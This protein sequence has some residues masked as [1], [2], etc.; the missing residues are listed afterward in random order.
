MNGQRTLAIAGAGFLALFFAAGTATAQQFDD[1]GSALPLFGETSNFAYL[2][3][4]Y[5]SAGGEILVGTSSANNLSADGNPSGNQ[6][7]IWTC[8]TG[9]VAMGS[10]PVPSA[11]STYQVLG[12]TGL[13]LSADGGTAFGFC[14]YQF[15][16]VSGTKQAAQI[17][18]VW[19]P[20]DGMQ[21]LGYIAG[22]PSNGVTTLPLAISADGSVVTGESTDNLKLHAFRWTKATGIWGLGTPPADAS[23]GTAISADG[24]VIT[25]TYLYGPSFLTGDLFQ[26]TEATGIAH[27]PLPA[28]DTYPTAAFASADGSV[29][30]GTSRPDNSSAADHVFRWTQATGT[31]G[32]PFLPGDDV[33]FGLSTTPDAAV[34]VGW[35]TSSTGPMPLHGF[36][37]SADSGLQ[38]LGTIPGLQGDTV[39]TG[40]SADGR[41]IVG[42]S[43]GQAFIWTV[44]WGIWPL[45]DILQ[46]LGA[47]DSLPGWTLISAT[48]ISADGRVITGTGIDPDG[49]AAAWRVTLPQEP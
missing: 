36:R 42:R 34:I 2:G 35:S 12:S 18:F 28:G 9:A 20:A 37:W 15:Q 13:G 24:S 10:V 16:D 40:V 29:V 31:T 7:F 47:G 33:A 23:S 14:D 6:A 39:P 4:G 45:Q 17:G 30:V 1:L 49:Q 32:L 19:T 27:I 5:L 43:G 38:D 8:A 21:S 22:D 41:V 25:G 46:C 11:E 3:P 26:W 48:A 44:D